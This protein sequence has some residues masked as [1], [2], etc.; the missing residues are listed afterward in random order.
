LQRSASHHGP[1]RTF[2]YRRLSHSFGTCQII[3]RDLQLCVSYF[4]IHC[5]SLMLLSGYQ[6]L[7]EGPCV[8]HRDISLYNLML[9][10]KDGITYGVL[11]DFDLAIPVD[12]IG[13]SSKQQ[14]GTRTFM[15]INLLEEDPPSHVYHHD[16]ESMIYVFFWITS[17]YHRGVET[18]LALQHWADDVGK[19][20]SR[21]KRSFLM[22]VP[23]EPTDSYS[24]LSPW[25]TPMIRM[26]QKGYMNQWENVSL[27]KYKEP[28]SGQP[29]FNH[30]T[31]GDTFTF[32]KF[33]DI[34]NIDFE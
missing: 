30:H 14:I 9:C 15:A 25:M 12:H 23:P 20:L 31:L 6:W 2:S 7:V 13:P 11:N 16:L 21:A 28:S 5:I 29:N 19:N 24:K 27:R 18:S 4:N 3:S 32:Q 1:R 33:K 10:K 34:L 22:E 26:I 17:R 8:F